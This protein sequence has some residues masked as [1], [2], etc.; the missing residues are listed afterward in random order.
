MT[1]KRTARWALLAALAIAPSS[2][3]A[4][5]LISGTFTGGSSFATS[6]TGTLQYLGGG[7]LQLDIINN[8]PGVF[9]AIGL[10]NV[11]NGTVTGGSVAPTGWLWNPT[12]QFGGAG[13]PQKTWS[14]NAPPPPA[15]TGLQVGQGSRTFTFNIGNLAY[16]N[17]GFGVHAIAGPGGCST[18]LGVWRTRQ[19]ALTTNDVGS[20]GY[21]PTCSDVSVPEPESLAL[22]LT[23]LAGLGFVAVRRRGDLT[24]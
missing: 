4:Q 14:W 1:R 9:A 23:G 2:V 12:N 6:M 3:D 8:G 13:L 19:G 11:P 7:I 17:I 18:K 16:S 24:A 10:V 15:H 21:D 20:S 5:V 22:L